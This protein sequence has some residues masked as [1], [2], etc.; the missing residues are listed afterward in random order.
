M[1]QP[2]TEPTGKPV[3]FFAPVFAPVTTQHGT[4]FLWTSSY[5]VIAT[6]AELARMVYLC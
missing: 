1:S 2:Q 5:C 3:G 4:C 6:V